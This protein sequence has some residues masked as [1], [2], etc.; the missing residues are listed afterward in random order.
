[1]LERITLNS[2]QYYLMSTGAIEKKNLLIINNKPTKEIQHIIN[3]IQESKIY[4]IIWEVNK[5]LQKDINKNK[6]WDI[7]EY[8][9]LLEQKQIDEILYIDSDYLKEELYEVWELSKIFWIR[10]RYL[11][12]NFDI[13]NS[14][15]Q[16]WLINKIP[17]IELENTALWIR[18]RTIKRIID[19]IIGIISIII[20][21]PLLIIIAFLIKYDDRKAPIIYKNRR[22]GQHWEEFNLYKFRYIKWKYCTKEAYNISTK[23]KEEALKYEKELIETISTSQAW[24]YMSRSS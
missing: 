21:S 20:L 7:P 14:N 2:I 10:Y 9:I 23:E 17:V 15:T 13:T 22:V 5:W 4:S 1:M 3:D 12:N 16:L 11:T 8:K 24:N 19:I 6:I 18:W